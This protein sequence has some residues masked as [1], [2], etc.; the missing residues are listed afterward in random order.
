MLA[1]QGEVCSP[2]MTENSLWLHRLNGEPQPNRGSN[3]GEF[4]T[5][6][7]FVVA[8]ASCELPKSVRR[9]LYSTLLVTLAISVDKLPLTIISCS[10]RRSI[11]AQL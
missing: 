3:F 9:Q 6:V 4:R 5:A 8:L 7:H 11:S 10:V 2:E 1:G